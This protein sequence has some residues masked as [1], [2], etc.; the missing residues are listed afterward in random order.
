MSTSREQAY[1]GQLHDGAPIEFRN[2]S[3]FCREHGLKVEAARQVVQGKA[4][5]H[6][7]W[8]FRKADD[9]AWDDEHAP[10]DPLDIPEPPKEAR[11]LFGDAT[12]PQEVLVEL[13]KQASK[14]MQLEAYYTVNPG[15]MPDGWDAKKK[16]GVLETYAK[17]CGVDPKKVG[18]TRDPGDKALDAATQVISL[19]GGEMLGLLEDELDAIEEGMERCRTLGPKE[20]EALNQ[21]ARGASRGRILGGHDPN[22][23]QDADPKAWAE[24]ADRWIDCLRRIR[25]LRRLAKDPDLNGIAGWTPVVAKGTHLLRFMLYVGRSDMP[26]DSPAGKVF[27]IGRPQVKMSMAL[28]LSREGYA[29]IDGVG[30]LAPGDRN[31]ISNTIFPGLKYDGVV[32]IAPPR[33]GKSD[34]LKHRRVM[35]LNTDPTRQSAYLTASDDMGDIMLKAVK[36]YFLKNTAQGRRNLSLYPMELADYD[37]NANSLRIRC[38]NPPRQ[39]QLIG[40]GIYTKRQGINLDELDV[41]DPVNSDDR[42]SPTE[43]ERRKTAFRGTWLTRLQGEHPF[44]VYAGYPHHHDDL[45]WE[46]KKRAEMGARTAGAQGTIMWVCCQ[47]VG[48]PNTNPKFKPI[49]P[50][51][52]D[53]KWL[54]AKFRSMN[55]PVMWSANYMGQPITESERL[56]QKLRLY[57]SESEEHQEFLQ[58]SLFYVG[59][60]PAAKGDGTGD[61][62]GLVIGAEGDCVTYHDGPMGR[63][64]RAETQLRIVFED[65][66]QATQNELNNHLLNLGAANGRIAMAYIEEVTGL[67]SAMV[68][69]LRDIHGVSAIEGVPLG[70]G[71][72]KGSAGKGTRL[73]A[74]AGLLENSSPDLPARVLFPGVWKVDPET[75]ERSLVLHPSMERLANYIL[76][77]AVTSGH[78]SLDALTMLVRKRMPYLT[79]GEGQFSA[80][81]KQVRQGD[82]RINRMFERVRAQRNPRGHV[83]RF[84]SHSGV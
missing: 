47:P 43:R 53:A 4:K 70:R 46:T 25:F 49:W 75:G 35:R 34:I 33:H 80:E 78:H 16:M 38:D 8:R 10:A 44:V 55:D 12:S 6:K 23:E 19:G 51:M 59:A 73:K 50:E 14:I 82:E 81:A 41:D 36:Q 30:L 2:L 22:A 62:A 61:P 24:A 71:G 1:V 11:Q 5:R 66:F 28:H 42:T 74:I 7:G 27:K 57:D 84:I 83:R 48:G 26:A 17:L 68:E 56:V 79:Q 54:E 69:V 77:F 67:G 9:P 40:H 32:I 20:I 13:R 58:S 31:P 18:D 29:M 37:N 64:G 45:L 21:M 65:E 15:Q 60:D 72:G 63:I 52:Y 39:P 76:N 3:A